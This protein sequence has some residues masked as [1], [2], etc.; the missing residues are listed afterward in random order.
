MLIR[1][2][3]KKPNEYKGEMNYKSIFTFLNIYD[4]PFHPGGTA[5]ESSASKPWL[6]MAVPELTSESS[7]DICFKAEALCVI[8]FSD[9]PIVEETHQRF[10]KIFSKLFSSDGTPKFMFM[11]LDSV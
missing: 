9:G 5:N 7:E 4:E 1:I 6:N 3:D 10:K 8:Y 2:Q 11:R